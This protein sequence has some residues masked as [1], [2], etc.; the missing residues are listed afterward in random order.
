MKDFDRF[1][2][3]KRIEQARKYIQSGYRILDIG[4]D[5]GALFKNLGDDLGKGIGIDPILNKRVSTVKYELIPGY[6]PQDLHTTEKFD[7][8][9]ML[10]VIEHFPDQALKS[11]ELS[12]DRY[13]N[14]K[15]KV[16]ITVPS[17]LVDYIL[18][19]S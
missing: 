7:L 9:I 17:V 8:I 19:L 1:L 3:R 2:Q 12:C 15:G 10:A 16:I 13:L 5:E 4:C 11:L 14:E 6:F 18:V